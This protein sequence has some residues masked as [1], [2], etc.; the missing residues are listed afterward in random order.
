M[1]GLDAAGK[2]TI[3]QK[4][5]LDDSVTTPTIG[6]NVDEVTYKNI[7]FVIWDIGGQDLI[8]KQWDHFFNNTDA[9]IFVID[10]EDKER[11]KVVADEITKL[12]QHHHL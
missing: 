1:L 8:R 3:S 10:S 7:T 4:L 5:R 2:T 12:S 6:F 9:I 11:M